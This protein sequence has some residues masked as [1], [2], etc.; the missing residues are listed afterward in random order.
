MGSRGPMAAR[1]G[2]AKIQFEAGVPAAPSHLDAAAK[3]EYNRIVKL[4]STATGYLQ[5]VDL[6][7]L[8]IYAQTWS[9]IQRL[10]KQVR[11]EGETLIGS[12]G[13]SYL[14]PTYSALCNAQTRL[15]KLASKLGFSPADRERLSARSGDA[16]VDRFDALK[17]K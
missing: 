14:N 9:D 10:T 13:G 5:Q 2:A 7:V 11:K 4:L 3:K 8:S 15:D 16:K 1:S 6:G 17:R 12:Q